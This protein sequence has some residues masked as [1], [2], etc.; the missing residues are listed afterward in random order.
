M[1]TALNRTSALGIAFSLY[2]LLSNYWNM[3]YG[4]LPGEAKEDGEGLETM[5]VLARNMIF[6]MKSIQLGKEQFGL[7]EKEKHTV[8][9][10]IR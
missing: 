10:F 6:L 3:V 4:R 9:N 7:P 8:T 5:R 2:L 1:D